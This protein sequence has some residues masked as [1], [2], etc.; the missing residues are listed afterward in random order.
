MDYNQAIESVCFKFGQAVTEFEVFRWLRNFDEAEWAMALNVLDKVAYYSSDRIEEELLT[1][2]KKVVKD[3]PGKTIRILPSG[4]VGKSGHVMAYH[5]KKVM[6]KAK[7]PKG[8]VKVIAL[9]QLPD[10][11]NDVLLILLDDFSGS[12]QS[13]GDFYEDKVKGVINGRNITCC[14]LCVAY[15]AKAKKYLKETEGLKIYGDEYGPA[16]VRRGSVFGYEPSM[17]KAREFCFKYGEMMFPQWRERDQKPLGYQNSQSLVCFEHTTP[18]NTLPILWYDG[19][20]QPSGAQWNPL[21][22][23]FA[24]SRIERGRRLRRSS[25]F[26]LSTMSHLKMPNIDWGTE[27]TT[28]NLRLISVIAQKYHHKS[29]FYIAQVLGISLQDLEEVVTIGKSKK[30]V[31][32]DGQLTNE[33]IKIY[34]EIRKKN[35]Y[36]EHDIHRHL[37]MDN[38]D[39][40]YVP[41]SFR[42]MT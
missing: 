24:N 38:I 16:F 20:I 6:L 12:G 5:M 29:D 33:A 37:M 19:K 28:D 10:I 34:E 15:M 32:E 17:K 13:I 8:S 39:A 31:D 41:K 3:Y 35:N 9:E 22:P 18:N 23:R 27:H 7:P 25:N 4:D 40:V 21:F 14:A 2:L 11:E 42:G 26:W 30:L 36:L 1:Q